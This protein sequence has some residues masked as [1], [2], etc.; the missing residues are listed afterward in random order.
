ML[1][2]FGRAA[3]DG[4]LVAS[5]SLALAVGAL[6]VG[7]GLALAWAGWLGLRAAP[8]RPFALPR[9]GWWLL[10]LGIAL[11]I[12]QAAVS[13]DIGWLSGM[14][15]VAAGALPAFTLLALA[16]GS[17]RRGGGRVGARSAIGSLA[18]GGLGGIGI[19][20]T[21]EAILGIL[22]LAVAALTI[23]A[24]QPE[25]LER[26]AAWAQGMQTSGQPPDLSAVMPFVRSPWVWLGA[27]GFGCV[28]APLVEEGAKGLAVPL[29]RL[30]GRRL[31]RLDGFLYGAAAG[32][33]FALLEGAASGAMALQVP[34]AWS[35][36][37]LLR[38]G[39]TGM[40]CLASG[41]AGLG[42]Q[43][44]L[45]ERRWGRAAGLGLLALALH[46]AWNFSALGMTL[47]SLGAGA[48]GGS[49]AVVSGL[50]N[51][52]L[53]GLLGSLYLTVIIALAVIPRRLAAGTKVEAE[54]EA[55]TG[56]DKTNIGT[57]A[58]PAALNGLST[59]F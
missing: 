33:G 27:L 5:G 51:L 6:G 14:A 38:A 35:A 19:A 24:A 9:W 39:A 17:A 48:A 22:A 56:G 21:I 8:G 12:G 30:T 16:L 58:D 36:L 4:N 2:W 3:G 55:E 40:H 20:L 54:V 11:V 41:L 49:G 37:M 13:S 7:L 57:D 15:Q 44:G 10:A 59:E 53:T 32:I 26:L 42:W 50:I 29:V 45:T 25:L 1:A 43:M 52:A 31:T 28:V 23:S 46:G 47:V 34:T 18:W